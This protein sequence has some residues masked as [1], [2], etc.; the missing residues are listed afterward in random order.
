M[1][2]ISHWKVFTVFKLPYDNQ[3]LSAQIKYV[4]SH[5]PARLS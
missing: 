1:L 2:K 5:D 3:K 4:L